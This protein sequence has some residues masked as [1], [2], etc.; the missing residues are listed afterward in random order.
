M[1]PPLGESSGPRLDRLVEKGFDPQRKRRVP[2]PVRL[3]AALAALIALGTASAASAGDDDASHH[4]YGCVVHRHLRRG[5]HRSGGLI[6]Q[7]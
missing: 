5:R 7:H 3:V 1:N 6:H 2:V 4:L